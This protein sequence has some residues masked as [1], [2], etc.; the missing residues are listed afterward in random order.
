MPT[1]SLLDRLK[2]QGHLD[3]RARIVDQFV[4]DPKRLEDMSVMLG[5]LWVDVSKQAWSRAGFDAAIA[6]FEAPEFEAAR[7][8]MWT[9][10]SINSSENRAVLHVAL[11]DT[12]AA[13]RAFRGA[14]I[15]D[16][17]A[18]ARAQM[19]A[20]EALIWAHVWCGRR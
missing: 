2:T 3:G 5:G 17:V 18:A 6:A 12:D 7:T 13:N 4:N 19:K 9:G 11:R 20:Y 10:K 15:A 8:Q 14:E 16:E 1:S